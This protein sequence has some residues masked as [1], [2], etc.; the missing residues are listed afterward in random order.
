[1]AWSVLSFFSDSIVLVMPIDDDGEAELGVAAHLVSRLQIRLA[2][3]GYFLR[4]A[5]TYEDI[6]SDG[7]MVFG[8]GLINAYRT[9]NRDA[10][11]P[12]IILDNSMTPLFEKHLKYYALPQ[13]APHSHEF[14][15]GE[16]HIMFLNYLDLLISDEDVIEVN[17]NIL[18]KH[19]EQIILQLQNPIT[20]LHVQQKYCWLAN[21][22]NYFCDTVSDQLGFDNDLRIKLEGFPTFN[23]DVIV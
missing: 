18:K 10:I 5:W 1:M 21:Y 8:K 15:K 9:E 23:I 22:H 19:K 12:G 13:N 17:W 20:D 11:Y 2:L 3:N 16:G 14:L 7:E 6:Y 4:G